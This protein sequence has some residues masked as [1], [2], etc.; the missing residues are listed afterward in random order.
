MMSVELWFWAEERTSKKKGRLWT[1]TKSTRLLFVSVLRVEVIV[2]HLQRFF[3]PSLFV[4]LTDPILGG[5][6]NQN[7]EEEEDEQIFTL[8]TILH[9]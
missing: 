4:W 8:V 9:S 1:K 6:N 7:D 2:V 3:F 5:D